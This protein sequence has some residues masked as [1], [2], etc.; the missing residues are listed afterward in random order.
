M[1]RAVELEQI[2]G[3]LMKAHRW[4][5]ASPFRIGRAEGNDLELLDPGISRHHASIE[6]DDQGWFVRDC[7]T[8]LGILV[9]ELALQSS[10]TAM[11]R[12]GDVLG[13]GAW[14]FR[15]NSHAVAPEI[16]REA[17]SETR[18]S[19]VR[20]GGNL[21]EQR[22]ELLLRYAGDIAAAENESMLAE[23]MAEHALLGSGYARATVLWCRG[24]QLIVSCQRPQVSAST[25]QAW[26]YHDSL[27]ESARS[28]DIARIEAEPSNDD[29]VANVE[30]DVRRA[31]CAPL[32]L[33]RRAQAFL[34][35]DSDRPGARRH[36]DA[37]TFCHAVARLAAL[38]LANLHRL[39]SEREH[40]AFAADLDRAREVQQ[41]LLPPPAGRMA[42]C[43]YAVHLHPGRVV[44]GDVADVFEIEGERVVVVLG[45]VSGAGL[46]A[47]LVMASVQSFLRAAF[48]RDID[49]AQ[50]ATLLNRHLCLQSSGGRF[51]T[52]WLG[53]FESDGIRC[54]FV[55]AGHGHALRIR[56]GSIE[57]VP[58]EG[59]IPLGIDVDAN[60]S[61]EFLELSRGEILLLYSDG[62]IE[63]RDAQGAEFSSD[64]L[65]AS[66]AQ[67]SSPEEVIRLAWQAL[68]NHT[69][70]AAPDDDA[71]LLAISGSGERRGFR[72]ICE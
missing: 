66:I 7:G 2:D 21:A 17:Q 25:L 40:A 28:G 24:D 1:T 39:E 42:A 13:I 37:P 61:A 68:Q 69:E 56:A 34:Y 32:M 22:L 8:L 49:P 50:V 43:D 65:R 60:F 44:A 11:L 18:I 26:E 3:P 27:V 71:T 23:I 12:D 16:P 20:S 57:L 46:G 48:A 47:G 4:S 67:A 29:C 38:A 45:D 54:R 14:R 6:R 64:G 72:V 36:S 19:L 10:T 70:G 30:K 41:R 51:V 9:N 59:A 63:Q 31:L 33:D 58:V 15:F 35:L 55:D 5:V 52:L 62:I 53:V